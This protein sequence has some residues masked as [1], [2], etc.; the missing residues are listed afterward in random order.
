MRDQQ[1]KE[2]F[3]AYLQAGGSER[4]FQALT[5]FTQLP[6]IGVASDPSGENFRDLWHMEA[7]KQIEWQGKPP[8]QPKAT[9][10]TKDKEK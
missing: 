6:Y 8:A 7:D 2:A 3:I 10:S 5:N 1:I 4:F 9:D